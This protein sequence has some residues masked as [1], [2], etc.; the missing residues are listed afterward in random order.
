MTT[1][2]AA[3]YFI[4][5]RPD[6]AIVAAVYGI[7]PEEYQSRLEWDAWLQEKDEQVQ[8]RGIFPY[9]YLGLDNAHR[10][11]FESIVEAYRQEQIDARSTPS[12]CAEVTG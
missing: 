2:E 5:N 12:T 4:R 11:R 8:E 6:R 1:I 7:T 9:W 3:A 10:R